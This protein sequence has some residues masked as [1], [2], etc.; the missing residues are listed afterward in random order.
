MRLAILCGTATLAIV[1]L[2]EAQGAR[3]WTSPDCATVEAGSLEA[4]LMECSEASMPVPVPVP[5]GEAEAPGAALPEPPAPVVVE[6]ADAEADHETV[7]KR[8]WL[9]DHTIG[10][11]L[12]R[13]AVEL[14]EG[15]LPADL[16][17]PSE[18]ARYAEIDGMVVQLDPETY[19]LLQVLRRSVGAAQIDDRKIEARWNEGDRRERWKEEGRGRKEGERAGFNIP[20]GHRPPPGSCR[21]WYPDRPA[22]HQPPPTSCDVRVPK[23]AV[24]V[25]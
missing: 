2:A 18:G 22:G 6:T 20:K 8:E 15:D 14:L 3:S 24:L 23:G 7:A 13:E 21:V 5:V 10:E 9:E 4:A 12:E 16:P 1:G 19:E 25:R 11:P 17:P